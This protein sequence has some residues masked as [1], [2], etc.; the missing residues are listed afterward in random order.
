MGHTV[1]LQ[2][3]AAV[4]LWLWRSSSH[5]WFWSHPGLFSPMSQILYELLWA[6]RSVQYDLDHKQH[7]L[8]HPAPHS[9][10]TTFVVCDPDR[11]SR[12]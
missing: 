9:E 1:T 4:G 12:V 5:H 3:L 2:G 7:V 11:C 6:P 10:V 8:G